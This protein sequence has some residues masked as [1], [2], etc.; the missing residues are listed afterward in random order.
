M[1][2]KRYTL[3]DAHST[4]FY[5]LPKWLVALRVEAEISNEAILLYL[6]ALLYNA[7]QT[8][9]ESDLYAQFF[10]MPPEEHKPSFDIKLY[11]KYDIFD[12]LNEERSPEHET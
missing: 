7:A 6:L 2:T 11:E 4:Q 5:Q 9:P 1:N 10:A 12:Y 8:A 3:S